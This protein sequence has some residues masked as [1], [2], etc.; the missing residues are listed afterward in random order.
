MLCW[1]LQKDCYNTKLFTLWP[2]PMTTFLFVG[3]IRFC[4][5][6]KNSSLTPVKEIVL[7]WKNKVAYASYA[8]KHFEVLYSYIA[9]YATYT[10][11]LSVLKCLLIYYWF[12]RITIIIVIH[13]SVSDPPLGPVCLYPQQ[14]SICAIWWSK[15]S[16][17][18]ERCKIRVLWILTK[19]QKLDQA[20]QDSFL[21]S[22]LHH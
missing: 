7:P 20:Q 2:R 18:K 21:Y 14:L 8:L 17:S 12:V 3:Q 9:A 15:R 13:F 19:L 5:L 11:L 22:D 6:P 16:W 1:H 10:L 4:T